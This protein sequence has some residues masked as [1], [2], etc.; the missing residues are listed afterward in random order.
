MLYRDLIGLGHSLTSEDQDRLKCQL[1]NASYNYIYSY[2]YSKQKRILNKEEWMALNDLRNNTSIIITKPDKGN[3]VVIVNRHDYLS[4]MKQLISDG[5]KFKL[6][7][8]NPTK[9]REN[10]LISYLR[11]LKRELMKLHL[12]KSFLVD[13]LLVFFMVFLK[14]TKLVA[15]FARLSPQLTHTTTVLPLFLLMSLN[16]SPPTN[17]L[18]RTPSLLWIGRRLI[19]TT[20]K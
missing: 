15:R 1:K 7:S 6:L 19:N 14:S 16:R 9:S 8:H 10:S 12:E 4:K 3:G 2:D 17:S 20:M 18:S 11:N 5:T 13:L